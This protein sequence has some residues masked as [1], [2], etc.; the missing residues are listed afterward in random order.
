MVRRQKEVYYHDVGTF[1]AHS[2]VAQQPARADA[3]ALRASAPLSSTLGV[4]IMKTQ[5]S[6]Q[7]SITLNAIN[8]TMLVCYAA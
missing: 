4:L 3:F 2:P 1:R 8:H 5:L 7:Q 6:N